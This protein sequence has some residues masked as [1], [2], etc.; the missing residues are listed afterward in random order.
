MTTAAGALRDW[1]IRCVGD[2]VVEHMLGPAR[3]RQFVRTEEGKSLARDES[4]GAGAFKQR[5]GTGPARAKEESLRCGFGFWVQYRILLSPFGAAR[6]SR[7][8]L[9]RVGIDRI[10]RPAGNDRPGISVQLGLPPPVTCKKPAPYLLFGA[11]YQNSPGR[12]SRSSTISR[13]LAASR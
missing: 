10:S 8:P 11:S 5:T 3:N 4:G 1:G 9:L 12:V 13:R 7:D 2:A 6:P